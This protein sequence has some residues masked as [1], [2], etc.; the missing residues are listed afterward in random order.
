MVSMDKIFVIFE[1]SLTKS[2]QVSNNN[3]NNPIKIFKY[4][5]S[6]T[7]HNADKIND[8]WDLFYLIFPEKFLVCIFLFRWIN[9]I[10]T[11]PLNI[12]I[13]HDHVTGQI[14]VLHQTHLPL[15]YQFTF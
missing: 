6:I 8:I 2:R 3:T 1:I 7:N 4:L 14:L 10:S 13:S 12:K 9:T 15:Q 11:L 5:L